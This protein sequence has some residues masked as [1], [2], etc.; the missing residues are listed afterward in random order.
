MLEN[1]VEA[2]LESHLDSQLEELGVGRIGLYA[3]ALE[4][5]G[6]LPWNFL[7]DFFSQIHVVIAK[8]VERYEL[9]DISG[10]ILFGC[11]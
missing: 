7:Q 9:D 8:F 5:G 1:G 3:L 2:F 11:S 4:V 10:L 6:Y